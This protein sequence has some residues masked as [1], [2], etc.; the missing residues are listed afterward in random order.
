MAAETISS[1][2]IP[3]SLITSLISLM[4]IIAAA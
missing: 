3:L 2:L 1:S 4:A